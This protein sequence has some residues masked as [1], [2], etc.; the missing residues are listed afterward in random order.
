[1]IDNI[2]EHFINLLITLFPRFVQ[3]I[4]S[5]RLRHFASVCGE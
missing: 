3:M 2:Y 5:N 1:M 4:K